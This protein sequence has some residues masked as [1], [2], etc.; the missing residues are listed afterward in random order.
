NMSHEIRTPM[1]AI[2]GLS[3][4]LFDTKLDDKQKNLLLKVNSSSKMLLGIINDILDYSK[5]E[6]GKLELEHKS[7][8][9]EDIIE[10]LKFMF[11]E[12]ARK[13]SLKISCNLKENIPS[14]IIGDE[15]RITQVLSN[16]I[17]NAIKFTHSG[18]VSLDVSLKEKLDEK[19]AVISFIVKDSGIGIS[20]EQ[21]KKLFTPFTQADTSTTRKYGGTGLGLTIS[22]RIIEAMGGVLRAE[23]QVGV[24]T[25]FGF[26][27]EFE[28]ASWDRPNFDRNAP[29]EIQ[30]LPNF[31]GIRVLLVE[32][33]QINQEVASMMLNR[34]AIKVDMANNG[35]EAVEKYF[36]NPSNYNLILMDLQMPV[37]SGYEATKII[38]ESDKEIPIV[39]LTAA[40]MIEDKQKAMD[41][42]MNDHLG[43]PIDMN[44]LYKT[45]AKFCQVNFTIQDTTSTLK[46]ADGILDMEYLEKIFSSK[47]LINKLLKNFS[48]EIGSKFKDITTLLSDNDST[49]PS[50]IHSL[51]GLSGNL[52]ANLLYEICQNIDAKYKSKQEIT[53]SDIEKLRVALEST[54]EKLQEVVFDEQSNTSFE[55]LNDEELK[56]LFYD[57]K[58]MISKSDILESKKIDSLFKNLTAIVD[59]S[60]LSEWKKEIEELEYDKALEIM[61]RWK[62][63]K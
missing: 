46:M 41:A 3:E 42:G 25:I 19:R 14:V 54:Q 17:S 61:N 24:G 48:Q 51:K 43:K 7:F 22:K 36:A 57:T 31:N 35:Q 39:A 26:E 49:T 56:K 45:V 16:L 52:R 15:L 23:S 63:E 28:A 20:E 4:L 30:K 29:Q 8:R 33:N 6:A 27:L 13:K 12:G 62:L 21:L 53:K 58:E 32:D 10:Q 44:E 1:N 47:E 34:V 59:A 18:S 50:L 9:L 5:I 60:E 11:L 38:R 37:M 55:K 40:A 2:I